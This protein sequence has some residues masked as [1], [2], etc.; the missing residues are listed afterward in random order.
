[1]EE[2]EEQLL[3]REERLLEREELDNITLC[4]E[5]EVLST[6]KSTIECREANLEPER[7][8]L[9]DAHAQVLGRK[10]DA[11]SQEA[12]MRDQEAKLAAREWQL[13]ERQM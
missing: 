8:A 5:L 13:A 2:L 6:R 10:L 7:K 9:E 11:D 1:V 3:E 12:G 4:R